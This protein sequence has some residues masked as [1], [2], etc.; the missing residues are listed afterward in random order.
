MLPQA[1]KSTK[2]TEAEATENGAQPH[3]QKSSCKM[4]FVS[5]EDCSCAG[6]FRERLQDQGVS[7]KPG[8]SLG[9]GL[10]EGSSMHT[11]QKS[12]SGASATMGLSKSAEDEA[13]DLY[14]RLSNILNERQKPEE[15]SDRSNI[16]SPPDI[17][18]EYWEPLTM[19]AL[20]Q[21][22]KKTLNVVNSEKWYLT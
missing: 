18:E 17:A 1:L 20:V 13:K 4:K 10:H 2:H 5:E 11:L 8:I 21:Q 22:G 16:N 14:N 6:K 15:C 7:I 3:R 12:N 9:K 19:E